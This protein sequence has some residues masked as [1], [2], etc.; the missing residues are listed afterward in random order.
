MIIGIDIDNVIA[1]TFGDIGF[2]LKKYVD[3]NINPLK[4]IENVQHDKLKMASF[5]I[6]AWRMKLI[7]KVTLI[8]GAA[9]TISKW[10]PQHRIKLVTS[11]FILFKKQTRDWLKLNYIHYHELYHM[12][13]GTKFKKSKGC[14]FFIEDNPDEC[15][16]L[17][18]YCPKVIILDH[19][20]NQRPLKKPNIIRVK[21]WQEIAAIVG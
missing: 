9:E 7:T 6:K 5:Y 1:N 12:K 4:V 8:E 15:E 2:F 17:A 11:R 19:P 3:P 21:N 20:W 16:I 10:Y 13:E 14:D 18:D